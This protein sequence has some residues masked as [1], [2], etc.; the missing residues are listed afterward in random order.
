[1]Q[2]FPYGFDLPD[3]SI[4]RER[5]YSGIADAVHARYYSWVNQDAHNAH[6]RRCL[7]VQC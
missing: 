5:V 7:L 3:G 1:M 2:L 4:I 6:F